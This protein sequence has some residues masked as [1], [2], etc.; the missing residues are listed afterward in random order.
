MNPPPSN[1]GNVTQQSVPVPQVVPPH[2]PAIAEALLE[3]E[4]LGLELDEEATAL[5][6]G[7]L[8]PPPS[9]LAPFDDELPQAAPVATM[10][11]ARK[12]R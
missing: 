1:A 6:L 10:Q 4:L 8:A 5:L 2:A 11:E 7:L 9:P 3:L 12:R